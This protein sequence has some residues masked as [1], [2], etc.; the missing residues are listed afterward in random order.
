MEKLGYSAEL[1]GALCIS[2]GLA[3]VSVGWLVVGQQAGP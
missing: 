1:D 2:P 3:H